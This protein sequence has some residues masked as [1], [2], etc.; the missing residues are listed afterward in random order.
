M[1]GIFVNLLSIFVSGI[2]LGYWLAPFW[3][4]YVEL[5]GIATLIGHTILIIK[6][7]KT[8]GSQLNTNLFFIGGVFILCS[9]EAASSVGFNHIIGW[10]LFMFFYPILTITA[11]KLSNSLNKFQ[12]GFLLYAVIGVSIGTGYLARIYFNLENIIFTDNQFV[13]H[14]YYRF[15]K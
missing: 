10:L 4:K 9:M 3:F 7:D 5:I 1:F 13:T 12:L 2:A 11:D 6:D 8:L 14:N 15:I